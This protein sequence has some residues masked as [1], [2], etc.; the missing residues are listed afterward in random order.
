MRSRSVDVVAESRGVMHRHLPTS[1]RDD[2]GP[3]ERRQEAA[4]ALA[5][6]AREVR[7]LG[8]GRADQDVRLARAVGLARQGLGE[9]RAR[10]AAG[11][12]LERLLEQALVGAA[13]ALGKAGEQVQRQ[14]GVA[15]NQALH[16]AREQRD[17]ARGLDDLR[18]GRALLSAEHRELA[19][20]LAGAQLRQRDHA[21]IRMLACEHDGTRAEQIAGVADVALPED[22]LAALPVPRDGHPGHFLEL[23]A[24]DLA[25]HLRLGQQPDRFV[26]GGHER[27]IPPDVAV[28][29]EEAVTFTDVERAARALA[30]RVRETPLLSAGELSRRVGARVLLK[31]EHLQLT[32]S[33]KARGATHMIRGL[34]RERLECG[35]VA[36]SAGNHAQA[37]AFAARE[38]GARAVLV[39]PEQAP[40]AKVAAVQQYGG[41]VSFVDGGYDEAQATARRLAEAQGFT[42]VHAFDQPE[43]VAGQGTIGLE[44]ARQ[45]P[46]VKLVVIPLGGGGLASGIGL[47]MA[48]ALEGVRVVGVQAEACAPYIDSLAAHR[49]VGARSANTICDGIAVKR[50]GDFTLP[51]VQ[52]YVHEVVTVSDDEV[53][54]AMV[55]LLERSKLVVEG[56]GAV[57]VAALMHG[58]V[59]APEVGAV[60]AVLSGGNVDVSLLSEAIRL[61]ETAAGRRMVLSTVVPDRPGALAGLLR[62]VADRGGNVVDVEHLRDG[63]EIHVRET[64]IKLVLQTRGN[65]N[66]Q[67]ILEAAR[68]EGFSVRVEKD[69]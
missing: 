29:P 32:G 25:E 12:G 58:R 19:E 7:Y 53:A 38:A 15:A 43:V 2:S 1:Q 22:H 5:R 36:A 18:G 61:G 37:V 52:R 49:P 6:G 30:G 42:V 24:L 47:A 62:V 41:E 63:I 28:A 14:L 64:A 46:D 3:F 20:Q 44:I 4:G 51:L 13:D 67:E 17:G 50:P 57:A 59:A 11:D 23:A 54:Q 48:S 35:V 39:M 31:A 33:F 68:A 9:Q 27:I 34:P 60:C 10:H 16:V 40:L 56:A 26:H 8:L 21:P 45:A 69:A 66:S 55:L 65:E